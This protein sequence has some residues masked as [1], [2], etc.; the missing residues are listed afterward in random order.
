[1]R[2]PVVEAAP[3]QRVVHVAGAVRGEHHDGR[4]LGVHRAQLRHR[5][6]PVGEQLEQE[7][8]ELVVGAVDLV[9]QEHR[10][11]LAVVR[12]GPEQR[13]LH[14]EAGRVQLVLVDPFAARFEGPKVEQ[15]ARVVP[16]VNGLRGVDP[17][18]ALEPHELAAGPLREHF[19]DLGL[20]DA[21]LPFQEERPPERER[22][23]DRCGEALVGEVVVTRESR[24][25]RF[26]MLRLG[27]LVW[28]RHRLRL[29]SARNAPVVA[30]KYRCAMT[31]DLVIRGG[32]IVDG[33]GGASYA[34]DVAIDGERIVEIGNVSGDAHRTID[35]DGALVTPGFVDIHTHLDAQLAWD[36]DATSSCWHGVT[37]VV[38]GNCGVTF[39]PVR[40]GQQS[41]IAEL[42]ESVEDIPAA[43]ILE[44]LAWDWE[45]YGEYLQAI[46]RMP[47]GVNV[48]G[49]I[50]HC[51]IRH[52]AMG[53]RGLD[54][55]PATDDDIAAMV[56]LVDEAIGAGALGFSTSRTLLHTVPDGRM[57]PGTWAD[58][59]ELLAIADVLGRHD[60]G[61]YEVA[62]RFERPGKDYE[63]TRREV[64]WMAEINRR[65]HRPVT[66]GLAH[67]NAGP[68]LFRVILALGRRRSRGR[69][70]AAPA[71]HGARHRPA[72]RIAAP[73]LLRPVAGVG[74][75]P[76]AP[77]R[78]A[79]R[80]AREPRPARRAHSRCRGV[81][82]VARLARR[83][84]AHPRRRRL[85]RRP[86]DLAGGARRASR[87]IDPRGVRPHLDR[88][89]RPGT[90]Q[91]S[92]PQ[93]DEWRRSR[94]FSTTRGSRSAS[95][96]PAPTSVSSWTHHCRR[97]SCSTGSG[98]ARSTRSR[99]RSGA[100]LRTTR[101]CSGSL[102]EVCCKSVRTRT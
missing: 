60:K 68:D 45:T 81:A 63:G 10:R 61:V 65:T 46:D 30:G 86:R 83:L 90:L 82:A 3:L 64:H 52:Y 15:L 94:S 93:S 49:M 50:G 77:A 91:L 59:R 70:R 4:H 55:A 37:S 102:I 24:P 12:E 31:H 7:G 58:E 54:K 28:L 47:K 79:A 72:L 71:D 66:F 48:G 43:S 23:E 89:P 42:M 29:P 6:R 62:P 69:R 11:D 14:Q 99:T 96:T 74:R 2:N 13:A 19:R 25:N 39:A 85:L 21:G 40:P 26:G 87:R 20:A 92:L 88:D 44:G 56:D 5:D 33:T 78:R 80:S 57:V 35:A 18:V 8:L 32:T 53:E 16:F 51:A 41:W 100:S 9:D 76:T 1:M 22:K 36:P 67:S 84:R 34:A 98:T 73:H 97:G 75:A 27:R 38:L 95:A 101:R 17:L